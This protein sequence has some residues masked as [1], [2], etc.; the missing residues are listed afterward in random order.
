M[1]PPSVGPK[2]VLSNKRLGADRLM[3]HHNGR[4]SIMEQELRVGGQE[5]ASLID[6][7]SMAQ[8][9]FHVALARLA[10]PVAAEPAATPRRAEESGAPEKGQ[11][12]GM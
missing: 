4:G 12:R 3:A 9:T 8:H 1:W 7:V 11:G 5:V 2:V 10:M 6:V